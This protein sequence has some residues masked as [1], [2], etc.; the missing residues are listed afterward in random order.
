MRHAGVALLVAAHRDDE[1]VALADDPDPIVAL[2]AAIAVKKTRPELAA[3]A[4]ERAI[5]D[6]DWALRAGAANQLMRAVGKA[7]A[8]PLAKRLIGD[9]D[10]RVRAAAAR[11]LAHAGDAPDAIAVFAAIGANPDDTH[12]SDVIEA[13]ADLGALDDAR[14]LD[15]LSAL[16]SNGAVPQAQRVAGR[17]RAPHGAPRDRW[18]GRRARRPERDRSRRRRDRDRHAREALT[19]LSSRRAAQAA[20]RF[21]STR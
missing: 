9:K 18:P 14:G 12:A 10:L 3:Q 5:G 2:E 11:V 21:H 8:L 4:I 15:G 6:D 17:E 19:M 7:A 20:L 1:L 13:W 16:V